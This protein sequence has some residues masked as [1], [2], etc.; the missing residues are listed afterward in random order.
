MKNN[1]QIDINNPVYKTVQIFKQRDVAPAHSWNYI[2]RGMNFDKD[3]G[4]RGLYCLH[5]FNTI[6]VDGE[7]DIYACICQVWLPISLG[8][9]WEFESLDDIIR[10]PRARAIQASIL[11]GTYRYCSSEC[12]I[13]QDPEKELVT[14]FDTKLDSI[15]W[16]NFAIDSSCNLT[17][18][19]CRKSFQFINQG[20][21]YEKRIRIVDHLVK[22]IQKQTEWLRFTLSGDGDPFAS[23]IYRE[24]LTKLNLTSRPDTYIE[25]VTNGI[26][27]EAHWHK[28]E[29]IHKNIERVRIS[30][31]A[32][33]EEIYNITRRG[34]DWNKLLSSSKFLVDWR[35]KYN[36]DLVIESNFVVQSSNY[37][38]IPRFIELCDNLGFDIISFQKVVDWGTW[39]Q[40]GLNTFDSHA[41]WQADHPD[42]LDFLKIM[43][44]PLLRGPKINATNLYEF[45]K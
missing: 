17:C 19:S 1:S 5:P 26:L 27:L 45:I 35:Q 11:D 43:K 40:D 42:H 14:N 39:T 24:L 8:K 34:G 15:N 23:L 20:P 31:D 18:P 3:L 41:I 44:N 12:G 6:T 36:K 7:G 13:L 29:N 28:L 25:L 22:L 21:E 4:L 38:D 2:Q 37:R 32:G 30:F 33:S 16:I 10:S 9:V